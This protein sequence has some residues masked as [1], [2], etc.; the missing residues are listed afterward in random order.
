MY[1]LLLIAAYL[2]ALLLPAP[3]FFAIVFVVALRFRGYACLLV[4]ALV[5]IEFLMVTNGVPLY[6]VLTILLLV[7]A[8]L[9]RPRLRLEVAV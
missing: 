4:A 2:T 6:T 9:I 3:V 7:G 1:Y 5:D 8:E